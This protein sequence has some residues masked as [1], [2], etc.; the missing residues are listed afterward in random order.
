MAALSFSKTWVQQPGGFGITDGVWMYI[1][2][3]L[4]T[5]NYAVYHPEAFQGQPAAVFSQVLTP[6][7]QLG[8]VRYQ[9]L[10]QVNGF[11]FDKFVYVPFPGNV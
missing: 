5:F 11:P 6:L 3:P 1:A 2:G 9:T 10:T 8:L 7:S 4:A